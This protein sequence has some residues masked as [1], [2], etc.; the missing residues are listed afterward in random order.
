VSARV[1][2]PVDDPLLL[3]ALLCVCTVASE[4]LVRATALR[5]A[6]TAL[7]VIVLTAVVANLGLVPTG[8]TAERP[9]P[10]YDVIFEHVAPLAI[11]WLVLR[12]ELRRVLGVGL[13]LL[14]L[15]AIGALGTT[16]GVIVALQ[17]MGPEIFGEHA[18]AM[19]GMFAATYIGGSTNFNT[20][21][22]HYGTVT[23]GVLYLAAI[24]VDAGLT[25]VWMVVTI[26]V[27]RLLHRQKRFAD[28]EPPTSADTSDRESIDPSELALLI[29]LGVGTWWLCRVTAAELEPLGLAVPAILLLTLVALLLAQ[30]PAVARLRSASPLGMFAVYLFLAVIGAHCDIAAV[31]ELG[32][33]GLNLLA[34]VCIL[35]TIHGAITFGAALLLRMDIDLAAIASQANI[36]GGT[37]ALALARGLGRPE[38]VL[39]AI[40]IG[41]L[42]TALGTFVGFAI[43]AWVA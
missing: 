37:T 20:I 6:G 17:V 43:A 3:L 34:F 10:V 35:L 13:P 2:I 19:A 7:V 15:F 32:R 16:V 41:S 14:A 23:Q 30:L 42:G 1:A 8:S 5:H 33:I 27:P 38:L 25:A 31:A 11:F 18:A 9:V 28:G 39:P 4:W 12:V 40:L 22:L 36:G 29:A 21:A 24:A 26:A